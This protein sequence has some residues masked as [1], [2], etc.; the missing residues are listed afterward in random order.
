MDSSLRYAF[1]QNWQSF[2]EH[3]TP[4]RLEAART[5]LCR[6]LNRQDLEGLSFLDAGSGS[7]LFSA[8]AHAL[9]ARVRSFDF[10]T[11]SV[12][13]TQSL[14]FDDAT[15]GRWEIDR[16]SLLDADYMRALGQ[17]DVVY[18]WGVAHHTGDMHRALEHLAATVKPGGTLVLAIYNDQGK[19]SRR[20]LRVKRLYH[21]YPML[22]P[23]LVA[24]AWLRLWG[25][26]F[27]ADLLHARPLHSWR[28]YT[29]DLRGMSAWHDLLDWVGGYPF[30]VAK[31]EEIFEFYRRR[32]FR[33][34]RMLTC[35]G[36][37]GCNEFV[38]VKL[39][40]AA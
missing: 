35:A 11:D 36:G 17:Y 33:M 1:G 24:G 34:E 19:P 29:S 40:S 25:V 28:H 32:G 27:A 6:L 22:R 14:R 4:E 30:E 16:G 20:W 21:Q 8:A 9:G 15:S 23:L 26:K 13:A 2:L 37:I 39:P 18:C 5:S 3:Y 31:P 12:A 7:G 10:D 38:F